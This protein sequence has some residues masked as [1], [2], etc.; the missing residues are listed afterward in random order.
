MGRMITRSI[1]M[2][3]ADRAVGK[4][5]TTEQLIEHFHLKALSCLCDLHSQ[6]ED[7]LLD[8]NIERCEECGRW[9][10]SFLLVDNYGDE[11]LNGYCDEC[12]ERIYRK[13]AK[14]ARR[15]KRGR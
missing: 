3:V 8:I 1:A 7:A 2:I 11:E 9:A 10:N 5:Y 4:T 14:R 6:L 12:R 15:N 13:E